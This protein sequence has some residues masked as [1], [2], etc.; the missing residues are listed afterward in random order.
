MRAHGNALTYKPDDECAVAAA[1]KVL[2]E[3]VG[4]FLLKRTS[5]TSSELPPKLCVNI[6]VSLSTS[7]AT[8]YRA[9]ADT[10]MVH[11]PLL[12]V[13]KLGRVVD[14][15]PNVVQGVL[16]SERIVTR[17][18]RF[19]GQQQDIPS[20]LAF[21]LCLIGSTPAPNTPRCAAESA[22]TGGFDA[23]RSETVASGGSVDSD[24][25]HVNYQLSA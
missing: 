24:S 2:S 18:R 12:V 19:I 6:F 23:T 7:Q 11:G 4:P 17:V 16:G 1:Q 15:L 10:D 14:A 21:C 13:S 8:A 20:K 22:S 9:V 3:R 25:R 5:R